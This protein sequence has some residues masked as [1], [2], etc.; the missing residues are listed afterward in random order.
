M[1]EYNLQIKRTFSQICLL[2]VFL[3]V[4]AC[5]FGRAGSVP[6]LLWGIAV[7]MANF[8][9]MAY[10]IERCAELPP[11]KAISYIRRG[12]MIR[13]A[14]V[15]LALALAL[16]I[17]QLDFPATVVGLFLLQVVIAINAVVAVSKHLFKRRLS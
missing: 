4:C 10:R 6:G 17:R 8:F 7:C 16:K 14:F 12:G 3:L 11:D 9:M 1:N 5:L 15:L 2:A 13:L